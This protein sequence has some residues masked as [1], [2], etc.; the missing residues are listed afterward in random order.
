LTRNARPQAPGWLRAAGAG[1]FSAALFAASLWLPPFGFLGCLVSPLPLAVVACRQ[2][3]R[4]ALIAG[5]VAIAVLLLVAGPVGAAVYASQFAAGGV[6][7]GLALRGRLRPEVVVGGYTILSTAAFWAGLTLLSAQA[8]M[9]P[10]AFLDETLRQAV[11][12]AGTFLLHGEADAQAALA[13]Q[14]W[15]EE[16]GRVLSLAFPGLYAVLAVL[17]G[18]LNAVL[19]R[20]AVPEAAGDPWSRWRAPEAWIWGLI[21]SGLLALL[22]SGALGAVAL[23]VFVAALGV[24]FLQGLAVMH[25]LFEARA[26][27]RLFRVFAYALL[28]VQLP[29]MLVVAG[30]GAFDLWFDFRTRWS[31]R[32]P[33]QG[34]HT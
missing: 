34:L 18:W 4:G 16:T 23:N 17:T 24:Y 21:A 1:A 3:A 11:Q 13:V 28:F 30:V 32:P 33:E 8:G 26:F 20:R 29:V 2:G 12:Q 9:G 14:T 7:V 6:A 22:T 10:L 27:P 15:A 19:A 31:P 5:G 25:H